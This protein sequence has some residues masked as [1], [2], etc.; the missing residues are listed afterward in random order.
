MESKHMK[1]L[2][3]TW[4][5]I[6]RNKE[7]IP[8]TTSSNQELINYWS[9]TLIDISGHYISCMI[10]RTSLLNNSPVTINKSLKICYYYTINDMHLLY[11]NHMNSCE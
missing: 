5:Y 4:S 7:V 11:F 1:V 3:F 9:P 6:S 2:N 10:H 8:L